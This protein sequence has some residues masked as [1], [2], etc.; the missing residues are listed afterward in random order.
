MSPWHFNISFENFVNL[1]HLFWIKI[2]K[3]KWFCLL[4]LLQ[5]LFLILKRLLLLFRSRLIHLS[6]A[7][8]AMITLI[9]SFLILYNIRTLWFNSFVIIR[10]FFIVGLFFWSFAIIFSLCI[11]TFRIELLILLFFFL[12]LS[13]KFLLQSSFSLLVKLCRLTLFPISSTSYTLRCLVL[14][15][16]FVLLFTL[17]LIY[18]QC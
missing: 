11:Y 17:F 10:V 15:L 7:K 2:F 5:F 1:T 14:I 8:F 12:P 18:G 4:I 6:N 16:V 9:S 3:T 13:L